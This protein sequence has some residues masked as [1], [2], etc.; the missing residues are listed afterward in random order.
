MAKHWQNDEIN[1]LKKY[2]KKLTV[3]QIKDYLYFYFYVDRS[4]GS[5]I[6]KAHR[7]GISK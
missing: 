5:I 7:L 4:E 1:Y 6:V 2:Y 3:S